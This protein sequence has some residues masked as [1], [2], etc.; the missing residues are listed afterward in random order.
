MKTTNRL[1]NTWKYVFAILLC[2]GIGI[3]SGLLASAINNRWFEEL[4]KPSWNPPAYLFG[5]VWTTLYLMMGISLGIIWSNKASESNKMNSYYLFAAQLFLN[6][7]WSILFFH[8][9]STAF[10]LIDIVLMIITIILTMISFSRFSKV[11]AWFL[12]PY[13]S[14]VTFASILNFSIWSLNR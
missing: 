13:I 9:H 1:S 8:F 6:F 11:A 7:M 4:V 10:A 3:S 2:E 12:V 5:P 14:W